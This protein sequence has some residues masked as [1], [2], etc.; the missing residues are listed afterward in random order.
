MALVSLTALV[1]LNLVYWRAPASE[2]L[3]AVALRLREEVTPLGAIVLSLLLAIVPAWWVVL[4]VR[5]RR[6][7]RRSQYVAA[8]SDERR[9]KPASHGDSGSGWLSLPSQPGSVLG[10][11][12]PDPQWQGVVVE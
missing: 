4:T 9:S 7:R 3:A 1:A 5:A 2:L 11:P 10:L 12:R 6:D 8:R